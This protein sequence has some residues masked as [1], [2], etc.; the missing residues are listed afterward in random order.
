MMTLEQFQKE[1]A[2][3]KVPEDKATG[4]VE[5]VFEGIELTLF[6]DLASI[7]DETEAKEWE[8]K[9]DATKSEEHYATI[10]QDMA[11]RAYSDKAPDTLKELFDVLYRETLSALDST[12]ET[13]KKYEAGDPET[14]AKLDAAKDSPE[15]QD[16]MKA[17]EEK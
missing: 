16:I 7:I 10:L 9:I 2:D 5:L 17:M 6:E 14:V 4:L 8:L 12:V 11:T 3:R 15:V 13:L 1:L